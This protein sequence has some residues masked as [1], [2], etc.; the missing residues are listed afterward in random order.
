[1]EIIYK[2]WPWYIAG[3]VIGFTVPLLLL[4]GNKKLGISSTLRQ[5]C[6]ACIPANIPLFKYDWKNDSWN[7]FFVAGLL[8]GGFLGGY[9]FANPLPVAISEETKAY[10]YSFGLTDLNGL[11]PSELFNWSSLTTI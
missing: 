11:M 10:F 7:L 8:I 4:I 2:P 6:A 1:M 3:P 9:V 5:I